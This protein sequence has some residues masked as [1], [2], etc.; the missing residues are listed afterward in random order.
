V[1]VCPGTYYE[2]VVIPAGKPLAVQGVGHPVVD[3]T[4]FDQG[5]L[6][7][8]SGSEVEGLTVENA[9]GEGILVQGPPVPRWRT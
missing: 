4:G 2:E 1:V 8:A 3:A 7:L 5:V 6:V 9:A